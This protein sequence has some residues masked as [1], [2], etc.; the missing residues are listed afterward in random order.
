MKR[1]T[2]IVSSLGAATGAGI[3]IAS[4]YQNQQ[5]QQQPPFS[6]E[7]QKEH[8]IARFAVTE[9]TSLRERAASQGLIYGAAA[10]YQPLRANLEFAQRFAQECAILVPTNEL[11]WQILRPTPDQFDF[12][13]SDWMARFAQKHNMLFRGHTLVWYQALPQWFKETV[14][15]KNAERILTDHITTVV[16][17]YAGNMHSWDVVNE[18]IAPNGSK[19]GLRQTPWLRFL[20]ADYIEM[21]FRTAAAADPQALLVYNDN[22]LEYDNPKTEAKRSRVL[23]LL[24]RLKSKRVPIHALGIQS[25]IGASSQGFNAKK[26]RSFLKEVAS[27]GLKIFITEMDVLEKNLLELENRDAIIAGVYQDYLSLVLDEPAV[28]TVITWGLS[29]RYTWAANFAPRQDG[30][31]VRPLPLDTQLER[32]LAWN[33]IAL[34][35]DQAPPR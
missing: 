10:S 5:Q 4:H 29:D 8:G 9:K 13:R 16:K 32:K 25:H 22:N 20:G 14:N 27:L 12:R 17:H 21:A 23:K 31:P 7:R 18:A 2:L 30:A 19:D 35:F 24:E 33:A 11:K 34:A 6:Q 3:A 15:R 26:L 1:R 28:N